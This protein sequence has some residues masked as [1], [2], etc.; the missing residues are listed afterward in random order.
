MNIFARIFAVLFAALSL[1][2]C[3]KDSG[4]GNIEAMKT[5][6]FSVSDAMMS[7]TLYDTYY[8]YIDTYGDEGMMT[9]FG[10]DTTK[11]LKKQEY[12]EKDGTTWFDV[13][14]DL[15]NDSFK[16]ALTLCE[17]AYDNGIELSE[18][19]KK[20]IDYEINQLKEAAKE[21]NADFDKYIV[22]LYGKGV[23]EEDVRKSLEIYRLANKQYYAIYAGKDATDEE[24]EKYVSENPKDFKIR[25]VKYIKIT[26]SNN[27]DIEAKIKEYVD[28]IKASATVAD[29][30]KTVG[31][32]LET[33]YCLTK[34]NKILSKTYEY[35]DTT[36]L[37]KWIF[38][39]ETALGG[40]YVSESDK[41]YVI[42]IAASDVY[43]DREITRSM[44]HILFSPDI[45]DS[46]E[47]SKLNAENIYKIWQDGDKSV[48]SFMELASK[49]TTDY[50]SVPV[51]GYYP[52]LAKGDLVDELNDWLF[53]EERKIGDT[54][55]IKSDAGY[56]VVY[57]AGEGL[58]K[59]KMTAFDAVKTDKLQKDVNALSEKY[60]VTVLSENF[61]YIKGV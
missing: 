36:E 19:D 15:A 60:E 59:W 22:A 50:V 47:N 40:T 28:K 44:Y 49:Y 2:S 7:Y 41:E 17:A 14:L 33:D 12:D 25:D 55:I 16:T 1:T 58:E 23:K 18:I 56:H 61:K 6:H 30:E 43:M 52:N 20:F 42:Y 48:A 53:D 4:L 10:I 37:S 24:I 35:S 11:S 51:G 5:E 21:G 54:G 13:F 46:D 45:Y 26:R 34:T 27:S 29:F 39:G 31:E 9:Y 8:Y 57:Y 3:G 38:N 32:F